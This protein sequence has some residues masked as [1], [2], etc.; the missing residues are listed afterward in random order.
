[1]RVLT[2]CWEHHSRAQGCTVGVVPEDSL[3]HSAQVPSQVHRLR[4][5]GLGEGALAPFPKGAS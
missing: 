1:M 5:K 4:G 2:P 3:Q